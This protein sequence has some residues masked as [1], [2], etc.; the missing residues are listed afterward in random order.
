MTASG[1]DA[2]TAKGTAISIDA[3]AT[4]N[5]VR[6]SG[7]IAAT[8]SGNGAAVGIV[9]RSGTLALVTNAGS[10]SA[11]GGK[12][13][14]AIDLSA[15]TTGAEIRQTAVTTGNAPSIKGDVLLGSGN[16]SF[17]VA[18]GTVAGKLSFGTGNNTLALSGDAAVSGD[19]S[20]GAG[21]DTVKLEGT[22]AYAGDMDFGG[23]AD[24]LTLAGT[25]SFTGGLKNAAG[26][27]V[28]VNGGRLDIGKTTA[29]IASLSVASGGTI[30]VTIDGATK[31]STLYQVA[32]AASFAEGA[33]VAV[34]IA[35][36]ANAEGRYT[37]V[38][39]GSIT[40]GDKLASEDAILPYMF[41]SD[42]VV[43]G[44][45]ELALDVKRKTTGE[46]GLNRSQAAAYDAV[47]AA[48][49]KDSK[50]AGVFLNTVDGD[51]FKRQV[52]QMLPD[53]AGGTFEAVT[54][55][56]RAT[57]GFLADP[58]APFKDEG[59]WG[60]FIQQAGWG[61]AK[62][63][64]DTASYDVS[65]WG[66][67]TGGEIKTEKTGNFGVSLAYLYGKDADGG[68]DNSVQSNQYEVAGFWRANWGSLSTW[69]RGSW[70]YVD[71]KGKRK[72]T[73]TDGT[74]ASVELNSRGNWNGNL[75]S[76]SGG[77]SYDI[78]LGGF[79]LRPIVAID[80][81]RLSEKAYAETGGGAAFDLSVD[82]RTSD[83]L[84][85]SGTVAIGY[86]FGD[87][88]RESG[89]MRIELEGGR[90][91][92]VGGSLGKTTARFAGGQDFTLTP[93]D[94]TNGWVGKI[95]ATGGGN[96]LKISGEAGAEEQQG[97]AA[98]SLRATLMVDF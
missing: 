28:A 46:L 44:A 86:E 74:G 54:M 18:D 3:G 98:I 5:A 66:I 4:V 34:K 67:S 1:G 29:T 88:D 53:H 41:R 7:A 47:Y 31:T 57:A 59:G 40:G 51:Q 71:F 63:L 23:G 30:G 77:A 70:A 27:A 73:G 37:F 9:D 49:G 58:N 89:W 2:T 79:T 39:A 97:Q 33:K 75:V 45:T 80:Y 65:G 12:T 26:L 55:G 13:N 25:A 38:R 76:G 17:D 90:R 19:A 82:K 36:I 93:E 61:R 78:W 94:R 43:A 81:Y 96:G 48:L 69:A 35:G 60:W 10:I 20:F 21:A 72:F 15:N 52:R 85:V 56:S 83:E 11:S 91:Q 22:S 87:G 64:G 8:A 16:D 50:V 84:A 6:N 92:L 68:T 24:S 62:S 42:V 95:R 32:G 14:T